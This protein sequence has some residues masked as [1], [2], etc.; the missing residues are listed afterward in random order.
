MQRRGDLEQR[1]AFLN[2]T[3]VEVAS[4]RALAGPLE[5]HADG[6]VGAFYRHLL[7]FPETR[8]LLRDSEVK[9]RL[10]ARQRDYLLSL[11]GPA[12]DERF[13]EERRRIG[14]V[15]ER[16]GLEPRYYLGAYALYLSLLTPIVFETFAGDAARAAQLLT[17]LQK[18]LM[19]DA[20]LVMETYIERHERELHYLTEELAREGRSLAAAYETQSAELRE[21]ASRARVAE[22]L[23]S[24]GTLVAGL[25]H[26]IGTPLGVIQGHAKLL[27]SAVAGDDGRWRLRTIQ[28][29][30]GRISRIIQT[31]LNMARPGRSRRANVAL[32]PL[33]EATLSFLTEKVRGR[34]VEVQT[35][36]PSVPSIV[37]DPER[38][39]QLF[40]NLFLNAIDAMPDGGV[41]R[42]ALRRTSRGGVEVRVSDTGV[43]IAEADLP[44]IFEPFFTSKAA[45]EGNGLGLMVAQGIVKDHGG[46]ISVSSTCGHGTE[47]R[48][49]F[50]PPA[51]EGHEERGTG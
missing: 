16:V 2:L 32:G 22:E 42:I 51:R 43:G 44:R 4:L 1:L 18:L 31:L 47:F 35:A 5:K 7:S 33:L 24:V 12:L 14:E 25:A 30:I 41:L 37:G 39:Q 3:R 27:E 23:A 50:P 28:E 9:N 10:L 48:I 46:R 40:L 45:G 13:L 6:F 34:R 19:L 21:T 8:E 49:V 36:L 15:H 11:A 38:L 29:Q 26:E 20:Q 17:A